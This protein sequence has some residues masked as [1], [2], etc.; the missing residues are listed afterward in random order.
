MT[1]DLRHTC[2]QQTAN[3]QK[4]LMSNDNTFYFQMISIAKLAPTDANELFFIIGKQMEYRWFAICAH[5]IIFWLWNQIGDWLLNDQHNCLKK[6]MIKKTEIMA[7]NKIGQ[8]HGCCSGFSPK[9]FDNTFCLCTFLSWD[10]SNGHYLVQIK[11]LLKL[12]NTTKI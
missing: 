8:N 1:R 12:F 4:P 5:S 10:K 3:A 11:R 7:I 9:T 2:Q 6:K